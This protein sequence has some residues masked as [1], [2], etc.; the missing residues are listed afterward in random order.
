MF[1]FNSMDDSAQTCEYIYAGFT[2]LCVLGGLTFFLVLTPEKNDTVAC[3]PGQ[4][5]DSQPDETEE[6]IGAS[7]VTMED[8]SLPVIEELKMTIK[9]IFS[10]R[11]MKLWAWTMLS[12][13]SQGYQQTNFNRVW[14]TKVRPL[15]EVLS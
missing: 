13:F 15:M 6:T 12:A 11:F 2:V 9:F 10:P 7:H 8:D 1:V 4:A 3:H 5:P 14:D